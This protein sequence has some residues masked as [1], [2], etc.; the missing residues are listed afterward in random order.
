MI[1]CRFTKREIDILSLGLL[2]M[3]DNVCIGI[4]YAESPEVMDAFNHER[5]EYMNLN[6]KLSMLPR[7]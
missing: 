2:K 7:E 6:S 4:K 5:A 3:I 1:E